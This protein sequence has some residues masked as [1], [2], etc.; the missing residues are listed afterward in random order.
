[1][2]VV[3]DIEKGGFEIPV[4][5]G[6]RHLIRGE[7]KRPIFTINSAQSY[8]KAPVNPMFFVELCPNMK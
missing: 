4:R 6:E 2:E 7:G 1:M 5:R 8:I 3:I